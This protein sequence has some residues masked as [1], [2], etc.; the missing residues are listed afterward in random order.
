MAR[1]LS[2]DLR[3][4]VIEAVNGGMSRRAAAAKYDVG[5]ATAIRWVARYRRTGS[6]EPDKRGSGAP[7]SPL[8]GLR[9]EILALV[10]EQADITLGEIVVHLHRAHGV[11]TSKSSVDRFFARHG[12]TFKKRLRTPASRNGPT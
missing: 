4:R 2:N 6:W 1:T 3:K 9:T 10:E 8:D 12:V 7:R 11:E 5:E